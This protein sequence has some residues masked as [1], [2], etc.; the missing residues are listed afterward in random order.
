MPCGSGPIPERRRVGA[1]KRDATCTLR[2]RKL[3]PDCLSLIQVLA[4]QGWTL[5]E[6][7]AEVGVSHET[8]R[9][10]CRRLERLA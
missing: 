1:S 6:I 3:D 7:A 5:R 8:V 10:V 2:R 9:A 4:R